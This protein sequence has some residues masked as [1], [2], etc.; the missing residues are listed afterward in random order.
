MSDD[1]QQTEEA[2]ESILSLIFHVTLFNSTSEMTRKAT[3]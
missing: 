3:L 2:A 1:L